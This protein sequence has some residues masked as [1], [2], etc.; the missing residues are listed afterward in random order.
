MRLFNGRLIVAAGVVLATAGLL[1]F[2]L[3]APATTVGQETDVGPPAQPPASLPDVLESASVTIGPAGGTLNTGSGDSVEASLSVPAG[4]VAADTSIT[5]DVFPTSDVSLPPSAGDFLSRA[6]D[7]GPD[8]I[9]FDPPATV[10]F[11][12]QDSEVAGLNENDLQVWLLDSTTGTWERPLVTSRD[13][14]LNTLTIEV[15]H[16]SIALLGEDTADGAD[17]LPPA[18]LPDSGNGG[19]LEAAGSVRVLLAILLAALGVTLAGT[20]VITSRHGRRVRGE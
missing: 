13:I 19:Y 15:S 12:Y 4:A 1:V 18:S 16:F 14:A 9:T 8:G 20:G 11:I 7:L 3:A 10:T 5:I 17:A 2:S 6:F